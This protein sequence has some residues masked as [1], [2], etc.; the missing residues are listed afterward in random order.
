METYSFVGTVA[1]YFVYGLAFFMMGFVSLGLATGQV[2]D[3]LSFNLYFLALFGL[4]HGILEWTTLFERVFRE[5]G[6]SWAGPVVGNLHLVLMPISVMFLL[7]FGVKCLTD[8]FQDSERLWFLLPGLGL[9]W[10]MAAL[11]PLVLP[12]VARGETVDLAFLERWQGAWARYLLYLPGSLLAAVGLL[13]YR[14]QFQA[15]GMH[16]IAKYATIAAGAFVVNAVVAG[17]I[18]PNAPFPPASWL[19]YDGFIAVTSVPPQVFRAIVAVVV[20]FAVVQMLRYSELAQ[21]RQVEEAHAQSLASE[22]R[23]RKQAEDWGRTM[24]LTVK[25]RTEQIEALAAINAELSSTLELDKLLESVVTKARQLLSADVVTLS[26]LRGDEL[27]V[28][29]A[30]GT[31]TSALRSV[32]M[33]VGHGVAGKAAQLNQPVV[34]EDYLNDPTITHE[35]DEIMSEEGLSSHM[36]AP[37]RMG[38]RVLGAIYVASRVK[39]QFTP[40]DVALLSRLGQQAAIALENARLYQQVQE[41]AAITERERLSRELHDSLAQALGM[42]RLQ[43]SQA[44]HLL[45]TDDVH[46]ARKLL[47]EVDRA[48]EVAYADVREAILGL[49][50]T[51]TADRRLIPLLRDYLHI[52]SIQNRI[53]GD[54]LIEPGADYNLSPRVEIQLVRIVQEALANVRKH[55]QASEVNITF[56]QSEGGVQIAVEDNGRGFDPSRVP[57]QNEQ[58]FGLTTMRERAEGVG[59]KLKVQ[60]APGRGAR[61]ILSV[62]LATDREVAG[63]EANQDTRSR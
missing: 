37:L 60:S 26:L 40:Q 48:T 17:L 51:V 21:R 23:A 54:L 61:V 4:S 3:R 19:N 15:Q 35:L 12:E 7:I 43:V 29:A 1:L 16:R 10:L 11:L 14:S 44:S 58:H 39:R 9:A 25:Q 42:L 49:R 47:D 20:A 24:E 30:T 18:V 46:G 63:N 22:E 31:Q 8:N 55:S 50:T 53:K 52:F 28:Q 62:P 32:S 34:V 36:A 45:H 33:A 2:R 41:I 5:T 57:G 13:S 59:G 6:Y 56:S 27:R 38:D